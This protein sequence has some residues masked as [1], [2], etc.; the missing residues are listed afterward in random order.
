MIACDLHVPHDTDGVLQTFNGDEDDNLM[1][2]AVESVIGIFIMSLGNFG[3]YWD[4][5]EDTEHQ[6]E[7]QVKSDIITIGV[8]LINSEV[9]TQKIRS[10]AKIW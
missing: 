2:S 6:L 9:L 7:G 1:P 3:D 4:N 5:L 10:Y 8:T